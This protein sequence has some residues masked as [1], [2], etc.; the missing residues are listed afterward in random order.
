MNS[1]RLA[2]LLQSRTSS[3]AFLLEMFKG[4]MQQNHQEPHT[5][6]S[7]INVLSG[8]AS[9][10]EG[11][12]KAGNL[13]VDDLFDTE[14]MQVVL[15]IILDSHLCGFSKDELLCCSTDMTYYLE[16]VKVHM[17]LFTPQTGISDSLT[18]HLA[19]LWVGDQITH[20]LPK[21]CHL[22]LGSYPSCIFHAAQ[23]AVR[24]SSLPAPRQLEILGRPLGDQDSISGLAA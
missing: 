14:F 2:D 17:P 24:N 3:G 5:Q 22:D 23:S 15:A 10:I 9:T 8:T 19:I 1:N 4:S 13:S 7:R 6:Q 20:H 12:I 18:L 21:C 16:T 11:T